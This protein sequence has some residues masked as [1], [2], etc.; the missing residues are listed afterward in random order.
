M[1]NSQVP[2]SKRDPNTPPEVKVT[3]EARVPVFD[4]TLGIKL[5]TDSTPAAHRLVVVGDSLSHGFQ[6]GAI[7][8]T[9]ISYPAVIAWEMGWIDHFR[10]PTYLGF[11]GLPLN[12]EFLIRDLEQEFGKE[13]DWYELP[14]AYFRA[15]HHLAQAEGWWEHGPGAVVPNNAYILDNLSIYGWD[16][17]DA[18]SRT[19]KFCEDQIQTPK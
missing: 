11:G 16:L 5:P 1:S 8:N 4:P 19:A 3:L 9:D 7:Y 10:F 12:L 17:R 15:R 13:L 14:L 2:D 18:L 6:S